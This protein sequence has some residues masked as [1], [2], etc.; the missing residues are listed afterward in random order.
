MGI[1]SFHM[2]LPR[3]FPLLAALLAALTLDAQAIVYRSDSSLSVAE[4][5]ADQPQFSGA[6]IVA[7]A[8]DSGTG[9]VID[10][11]WVLTAKHVVT[12]D[13]SITPA[14][15]AVNF[16]YAGGHQTS[17]AI[18]SDP[19]SDLA[20]V[21]F[22][23]ALPSTL[24]VITPNFTGTTTV[25]PIINPV[26]Q[27]MWNIGYGE[28]GAYP[29]S[30]LTGNPGSRLGGT[31]IV[32]NRSTVSGLSGTFLSF[33]NENTSGTEFES[34]TAPGD[35]GGPMYIQ[36]GY[37]WLVTGE[38]YGAASGVGYIDTDVTTDN[39]IT[40]TTGINFAARAQ[41]TSVSWTSSYLSNS[42]NGNTIALKT[43]T[44]GSGVWDISRLNFTDKTYTYAWQNG[45][46]APV[47]FG[48]GSGAAG[49]VM[50]GSN[51]SVSNITFAATGSGNYTIAGDSAGAYSLALQAAGSTITTNIAAT[52]SAPMTNVS[53][54]T[55]S[56]IKAGAATLTLSGVN[57]YSGGTSINAG[58]LALS[59]S[60]T[61]GATTGALAINNSGS[62]LDL[63]GT[64]QSVGNFTG[65]TGTVV[66]NNGA[67]AG[68]LIVGTA[69][70]S[71]TGAFA[72]VLQNGTST[73]A[74]AKTGTGT[75]TLAGANT[76]SG[77]TTVNAGT[78]GLA[79]GS[80]IGTGAL[81]FNGTGT[82]DLG[83]NSQTVS[84]LTAGT[85]ATAFTGTVTNGS[86]T[87]SGASSFSYS[88]SNTGATTSALDLSGLTGFTYAQAASG[89]TFAV[90]I[91]K[92]GGPMAG[93]M[94]NLANG[95]TGNT[96]TASN[97]NV[98]TTASGTGGIGTLN[99][100]NSNTINANAIQL[101][102]YRSLGGTIQFNTTSGEGV[103]SGATL[104]LRNVSGG[105][106]PVSSLTIGN[107]QAGAGTNVAVFDTSAG[108]VNAIVNNVYVSTIG[109]TTPGSPQNGTLKLG[110]GTF[111]TGT[112]YLGYNAQNNVSTT[113]NNATVTQNAGAVLANAVTFAQNAGTTPGTGVTTV[114]I[115]N[116][117]TPSTTAVLS[118][119]TINVGVASATASTETLNFNN[120]TIT[121]YDNTANGFSGQGNANGS[122]T[123]VQNLTIQG[124]T[125]GGAGN[126][127]TTLTI[128]LANTGTHTFSA[129]TGNSI[130]VASTALLT[131]LGSLT[132]TGAGTLLLNGA[133]NYSGATNVTAGTLLVNGAQSGT[134]TV[135][136]SGS[137]T[138]LGGTGSL[139]APVNVTTG[140]LSAGSN[141]G[142][143]GTA[144]NVGKLTV[145]TLTLSNTALAAFDLSSGVFY[146][147][148][149]V[150]GNVTLGSAALTLNVPVNG[151]FSVGQTLDL[152]HTT[153]VL[154]GT[155]AGFN[156]LG[157]YTYGGNS[158]EALYT[159]TDFDL[160][161]TAV[162]E[163]STV[164]LL[165]GALLL[166]GVGARMRRQQ[167][168]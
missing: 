46:L 77:G 94:V 126:N 32:N 10:S 7:L 116:L 141:A 124:L 12:A 63:G 142:A 87:V 22:A 36:N 5:I 168:G 35:S 117:G 88:P 70:T 53:G 45:T 56:L 123:N 134:G 154:S 48:V 24:A 138:V 118:A 67:T 137:N 72:G 55:S 21:Y 161:L 8:N 159:P 133:N 33:S 29:G 120:G 121:N 162:P 125:G 54:G 132:K 105:A 61:L 52:I 11:H 50:L 66:T 27:Q 99:L 114:G 113:T 96:I 1:V 111:N 38:V 155:F 152:I 18:Y 143:A 81:T 108:A 91:G 167:R 98:G 6:G 69:S 37:Q 92:S 160:V 97:F 151:A 147:Q 163:P 13:G 148:L 47:T 145:G 107:V 104:T 90:T 39:F 51:I 109:T 82:L 127:N 164:A 58:T 139:A 158:F 100:G 31:N 119:G 89:Q 65:T 30:S 68:T 79:S 4:G 76:Y 34:S 62:V 83:T 19:N 9:E 28:Y 44:D 112:I 149:L 26:G 75:I 42:S 73:L 17:S 74:L 15:N 165:G 156:N 43:P 25:S 136:V 130:T 23:T 101:G 20:L 2:L 150:N 86:L 131:G 166:V 84:D 95:V 85:N 57:G 71:T 16:Y 128:N 140:M 3:T 157:I 144:A 153:G 103:G 60:G 106:T 129:G 41:A 14:S 102:G 146:D 40:T 135:T 93:T 110:T 78:L 115:Y 49:T 59:G 80:S 64:N 122:A